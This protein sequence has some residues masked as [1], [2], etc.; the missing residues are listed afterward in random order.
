VPIAA[1]IDLA[2][3]RAIEDRKKLDEVLRSTIREAYDRFKKNCL[4]SP[5]LTQGDSVELL[6]NNWKPV[7]FLFHKLLLMGLEFRV[8]LGASMIHLFR[9]NADEC[10]GPAFWNAREALEEVKSLKRK[11]VIANFKV[12]DET[13]KEEITYIATSILFLTNL[14]ALTASQLKYC[15]YYLW[16]G[17]NISQIAE[18]T[19]TSKSNVSKNLARTQCYTLKRLIDLLENKLLSPF[20]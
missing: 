13:P 3:S 4:A 11:R 8:G 2:E 6:V 18:M 15:Y 16:E 10:D 20:P 14:R 5:T 7:I 9:E 1:I 19:K 17:K 12:E